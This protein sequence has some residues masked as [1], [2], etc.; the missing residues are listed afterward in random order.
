MLVHKHLPHYKCKTTMLSDYMIGGV[1]VGML[2]S[3]Q[4]DVPKRKRVKFFPQK[5]P[6][7]AILIY[8]GDRKT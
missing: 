7:V 5:R 2:V 6:S 4:L 3:I 8:D 1:L